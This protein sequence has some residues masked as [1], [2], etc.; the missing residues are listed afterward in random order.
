ML[1]QILYDLDEVTQQSLDQE[2]QFQLLEIL[3][4]KVIQTDAWNPLIFAIYY[5]QYDIVL[6]LL[7]Q[8]DT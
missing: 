3:R 7:K 6:Y 1:Q 4:R 8:T 5:G 2:R